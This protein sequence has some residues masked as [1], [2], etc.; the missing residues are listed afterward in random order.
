MTG[1]KRK[2]PESEDGGKGKQHKK[3]GEETTVN[4]GANQVTSNE[5][6]P[7]SSLSVTSAPISS[8]PPAVVS[9]DRSPVIAIE[10]EEVTPFNGDSE[11]A[12]ETSFAA[13][14]KV[15][16][17]GGSVNNDTNGADR[18]KDGETHE[19]SDDGEAEA[20]KTEAAP[21]AAR[22][23]WFTPTRVLSFIAVILAL[24]VSFVTALLV[25]LDMEHSLEMFDMQ[26]KH[27]ELQEALVVATAD[28]VDKMSANVKTL[29]RQLKE[30]RNE[31]AQLRSQK[32]GLLSEYQTKLEQLEA[33]K[34]L[35]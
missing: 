8:D 29:R 34:P 31:I 23:P 20:T 16:M 35:N 3:E 6:A 2:N 24:T 33:Q 4:G 21:K 9:P 25:R 13:K 28:K 15:V 19:I 17:N 30:A 12:K 27:N 32:D 11:D 18:D 5:A 7:S 10:S 1:K 14:A 22:G 26:Q